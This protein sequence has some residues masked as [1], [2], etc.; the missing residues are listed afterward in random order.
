[1]N[2]LT[3]DV[4]R[5]AISKSYQCIETNTEQEL[6]GHMVYILMSM[7]LAANRDGLLAV[8]NL[9]SEITDEFQPNQFLKKAVL[10]HNL[11]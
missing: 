8:E 3:D 5:D 1:M 2:K 11:S 10:L 9:M 6:L 7:N 4:R